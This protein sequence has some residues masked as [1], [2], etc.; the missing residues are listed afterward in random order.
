MT[1]NKDRNDKPARSGESVDRRAF[2]KGAATGVTALAVTPAARAQDPSA[3]QASYTAPSY[4]QLQRDTGL[5]A[6]PTVE[7]SV[8]RPGSDLMVQVLR[9]MGIEFVASN[10]GSSFEGIQESIANYGTPPNHMPEYITALHE[11]SSVDMANGY[12]KAE[13]KPMAAMLHGTIGIQHA[14]MAIYQAFYSVTPLVLIVGRDDGFIQ[15]HTANDMTDMIRSFPKWDTH[16][17]TLP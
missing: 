5:L 3:Y 17:A 1:K 7:R 2:L 16:P 12:G 4:Q 8:V 13:G 15:A 11:E 14:A 10:N 9:D 6:P